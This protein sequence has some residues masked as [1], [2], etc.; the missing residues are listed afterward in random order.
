M[1]VKNVSKEHKA[2]IL[3][4]KILIEA[5][6]VEKIELSF[7]NGKT[8][9]LVSKGEKW[10]YRVENE[11]LAEGYHFMLVR[12]TMKNG[13]TAIE[14]TII[15]IDNTSP[16]IRLISPSQ[17]G[18]YNQEL[19]F[20][21]LTSDDIGLKN[22]KLSLRK[23]DK[24]SYEVPSFIQGLYLDWHFWGATL[25]DIGVGLTFFDDAVKI[26]FQ[27]GQFTQ[28]QRDMFSKT[29][30]RYGGDSVMG[31]KI[32]ANVAQIPFSYFLGHDWEW[33]SASAAVGAQFSYFNESGSEEGQILSALLAQIEF[34]KVTFSKM[35]MFSS[36]SAYS[37]VSVWFI[38]SDVTGGNVDIDK[39]V[40][41]FSEGIRVSIF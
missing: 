5:K 23:G 11:D 20:S 29:D 22:V 4:K 38:P 37:E 6:K 39:F 10:M 25:F 34:P 2:E 40:P 31:V 33:L 18:R 19:E 15:Q 27:W 26:Q 41:Q 32:L 3:E 21:G 16:K 36:F 30:M 28:A 13:E 9:T 12:A 7:D 17:G 24:S 35:K 1:K 14:R 8:F